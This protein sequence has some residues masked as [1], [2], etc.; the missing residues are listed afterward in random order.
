MIDKVKN[1]ILVSSGKGGVG[2]ST[3]ASNLAAMFKRL[4]YRVGMLDSDI[5]GPSQFKMFGITEYNRGSMHKMQPT[6]A[7]GVPIICS[8]AFLDKETVMSWRGPMVSAVLNTM[9]FNSD[10]PELDVLVVDMPPGTGDVQIEICKKLNQA[11]AVIVT[12]PQEVALLDC[13]KGIN[14]FIN[15]GVEILGIVENMSKFVCS[16]C[17]NPE[18]IFGSSKTHLLSD[19]YSIDILA[20]IP[21]TSAI[22]EHGDN[23]KPIVL[24]DFNKDILNSYQQL[25]EFIISKLNITSESTSI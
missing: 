18:H 4:N 21:I 13:E 15:A 24:Q 14:M 6:V 12:T 8:A 3:V 19:R 9:I 2:K 16:H 20:S 23:G 10:W 17:G 25:A 1:I 7:H 5:Y 11:K 22:A